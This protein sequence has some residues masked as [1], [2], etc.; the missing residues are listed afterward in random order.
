VDKNSLHKDEYT[1]DNMHCLTT[2]LYMALAPIISPDGEKILFVGHREKFDTHCTEFEL[3]VMERV[4]EGWSNPSCINIAKSRDTNS[5]IPI[6][7]GIYL[8]AQGESEKIQFINNHTI[9]VPSFTCGRSGI[10]LIDINNPSKPLSIFPPEFAGCLTSVVLLRVIGNE[11]VFFHQ[12]YTCQRS[13]WIA[14]I[15]DVVEYKKIFETPK[16]NPN[17]CDKFINSKISIME[18][19]NCSAW[20][21]QSGGPREDPRPLIA[22]L[23]GGPFM[24]AISTFSVEMAAFLSLGYDIV[25]PNY[26]G[27]FS[28]GREFLHEL[29][30]YVGIKDVD[31]CHDCVVEAKKFLGS[32]CVVAYG[33]SHGG[34]LT[35]WLLGKPETRDNFIGGV[36]WNPAV[37][38]VSSNLTSDIPDW[39]VDVSMGSLD[40]CNIFAP[41]VKFLTRA[42]SQ[43][44][45]S[46]VNNV[47][48]PTLVLLGSNDRRVVPCAGLRWAQAI[49]ANNVAVDVHWY[50]DQ[51]HAIQGPEFYETAIITVSLW[52]SKLVSDS[53]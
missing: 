17:I 38:L 32:S 28:F 12:G 36:L 44:P 34:F 23:H 46:V 14:T 30:G 40:E 49:K 42:H 21:L 50:P 39:A 27:S 47:K 20:L 37:D 7:N 4:D 41:S 2:D 22:Y 5:D 25:I 3:F 43:S 45:I 48:V 8:S 18:A 19:S 26:R 9:V 52:I 33:G 24:A 31:D 11:I 6:F 29:E 15:G 1:I 13:V 10:F 16:L 51:G 53:K 35:A